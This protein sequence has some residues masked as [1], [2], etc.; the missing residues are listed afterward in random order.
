MEESETR[1]PNLVPLISLYVDIPR[2]AT[3]FFPMQMDELVRHCLS[4]I[5]SNLCEVRVWGI[6]S[7]GS[8]YPPCLLLAFT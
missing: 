3:N 4:F 8:F 5:L 6:S 7:V 1:I 2:T